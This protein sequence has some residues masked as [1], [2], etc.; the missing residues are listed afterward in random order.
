MCR[1]ST[2]RSGVPVR[3][4][5][6]IVGEKVVCTLAVPSSAGGER[7]RLRLGSQHA[8]QQAQ[9]AEPLRGASHHQILQTS[10]WTQNDILAHPSSA[11][12]QWRLARPPA[13]APAGAARAAAAR[14]QTPARTPSPAPRHAAARQRAR[15]GCPGDWRGGALVDRGYP[16]AELGAQDLRAPAGE[17]HQALRRRC[18]GTA[19]I[20]QQIL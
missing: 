1:S 6:F 7:A 13:Y 14:R 20:I 9:R 3:H 5:D 4:S 17:R 19:C 12:L 11:V 16:E 18:V 2:I 8:P 15:G 10:Q